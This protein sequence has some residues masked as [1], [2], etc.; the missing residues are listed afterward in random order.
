[1]RWKEP[2]REVPRVPLHLLG[3]SSVLLLG[4]P[5][6]SEQ[7]FAFG[8]MVSAPGEFFPYKNLYSNVLFSH[9]F[10]QQR[11]SCPMKHGGIP[12]TQ[13]ALLQFKGGRLQWPPLPALSGPTSGGGGEGGAVTQLPAANK[14][15][16][17]PHFLRSN[18]HFQIINFPAGVYY[19]V[20]LRRGLAAASSRINPRE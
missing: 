5:H 20:R 13:H 1:M 12:F 7:P 18:F 15:F 10:T 17:F 9:V 8:V 6:L 14:P 4:L 16:C 3:G 2:A 11:I 19:S